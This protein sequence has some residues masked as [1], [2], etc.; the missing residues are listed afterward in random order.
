MRITFVLMLL[1]CLAVG[2]LNAEQLSEDQT[3]ARYRKELSA[4]QPVEVRRRA[5]LIIG[6][7]PRAMATA[8]LIAALDDTDA[9]VRRNA[10]VSICENNA[11]LRLAGMAVLRRLTD[12][13]VTVRRLASSVIPQSLGVFIS[14]DAYISPNAQITAGSRKRSASEAEET[15]RLLTAALNDS[16]DAVRRNALLGI[17]YFPGIFDHATLEKF[18]DST[19]AEIWS[20][21]LNLYALR[22]DAPQDAIR[23]RLEERLAK[24]N[25]TSQR[26]IILNIV[27]STKL[28]VAEPLLR[29][30]LKDESSQIRAEALIELCRRSNDSDSTLTELLVATVRAND[31]ALETRA[32]AMTALARISMDDVRRFSLDET[33]PGIVRSSAW[34]CRRQEKVAPDVLIGALCKEPYAQCRKILLNM[35]RRDVAAFT[36]EQWQQLQMCEYDDVRHDA[37]EMALGFAIDDDRRAELARDAL[38]DDSTRVRKIAI[39]T[40]GRIK[41]NGWIDDMLAT[42][43]D[44]DDELAE[45]AAIYLTAPS[46]LRDKRVKTALKQYFPR[47]NEPIVKNRIQRMIAP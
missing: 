46:A 15:Q 32:Q 40:I 13:D 17:R 34:K 5:A 7:Y 41:P 24:T 8:A 4:N 14:G 23:K 1:M 2:F 47:C 22:S 31:V 9:V 10:L 29:L 25:D 42:L 27:R 21:A 37:L 38:L 3:I 6:K 16:D 43:E 33:L 20:I 36:P 39:K 35:L 12:D 19:D 28:A 44:P 18:I 45:T 11:H 30:L 26:R